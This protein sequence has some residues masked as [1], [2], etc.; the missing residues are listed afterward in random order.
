MRGWS[1]A[2]AAATWRPGHTSPAT[3][4]A[5]VDFKYSIR[6][7]YLNVQLYSK[8]GKR[9]YLCFTLIYLV[10]LVDRVFDNV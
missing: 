8:C 4:N 1:Q 10:Y 3:S 9:K 5:F 7:M 2:A 6:Y